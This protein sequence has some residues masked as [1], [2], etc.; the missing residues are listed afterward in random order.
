MNGAAVFEEA[1]ADVDATRCFF[2]F[3]SVGSTDAAFA[4]VALRPRAVDLDRAAGS[5]WST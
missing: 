3:A 2:T 4:G 5:G 1:A